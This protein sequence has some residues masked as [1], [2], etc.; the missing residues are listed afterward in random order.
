MS[1]RF[2]T[3][4]RFAKYS[5]W[6]AALLLLAMLLAACGAGGGAEGSNAAGQTSN[7]GGSPANAGTAGNESAN[8]AE[9]GGEA[10]NAGSATV[11]P[12]VVTDVTGAEITLEKAPERVVMLGPS[13]TEIVFAIGAGSLAVGADAYSNYP[14][15]AAELPRVGDMNTNIEAVAALNPDLVLASA[16]MNAAAVDALRQLGITVYASDP[17]TLDE[18]IAH[19][20]QVGVLLNRREGAAAAADGMRAAVREVTEKVKNA[21]PVSVYLEFSPGWTIGTGTFLDELV[22][23][24]GGVNISADQT[25]WF[26]VDPEAVIGKNPAVIIYPEI[27][28]VDIIGGI[29]ARPGWDQIDAVKNGR[30]HAVTNDPLVRVGPRLTDG[31]KEIAA[32]VHPDLF[33]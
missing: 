9:S 23:L 30:L 17:Q 31:L 14:P 15:E 8:E 5:A 20:E 29:L 16:S 13:D 33:R 32:A 10:E 1:E 4:Q 19:I 12:L 28:G 22:R 11:Y 3:R 26:E 27:E 24:A 18:T 7:G 6:T 25:G 2:T 21:E